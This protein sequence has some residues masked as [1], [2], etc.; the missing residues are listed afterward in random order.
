MPKKKD[1]KRVVRDRMSKTGE[2]YTTARSQVLRKKKPQHAPIPADLA[3]I[4]GMSDAAVEAKTGKDWRR[5]VEVLDAI[6]A[7]SMPHKEIAKY[8]RDEVGVAPWWSQ[9]VTGGY[10]RIRGLREKNQRRDGLYDANKSKT[11]P[12]TV[13]ALFDGFMSNLKT[14]DFGDLKITVR[15]AT[16]PKSLR[17]SA[18]PGRPVDANFWD[19][20][21]RKSQV[22]I[23]HSN[24]P[25]KQEV[26]RIRQVW[27]EFLDGLKDSFSH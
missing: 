4:T 13:Q 25:S 7:S 12:V 9:M 6:D 1:L 10:E 20:G 19:K 17:L 2:S 22:Q 23:Q 27:T 14:H 26:T 3:A 21:E 15:K 11:F 16:R 5:W 24:L 18:G 8:L